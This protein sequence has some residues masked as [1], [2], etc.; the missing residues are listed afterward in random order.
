MKEQ[1]TP[2][3]MQAKLEKKAMER[4]AK[5]QRIEQ[6]TAERLEK[7]RQEFDKQQAQI[8]KML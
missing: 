6:K 8:D 7:Q 5:I 4:A 1:I 3:Q 2:E